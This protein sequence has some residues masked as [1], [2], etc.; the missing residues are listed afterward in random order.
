MSVCKSATEIAMEQRIDW[1][2]VRVLALLEAKRQVKRRLQSE[3]MVKVPL[4]S[5]STISRLAEDHLR[6]HPDLYKQ[7]MQSDLA[8]QN[9]TN[10]IKP[11]KP[12]NQPLLMCKSQVQK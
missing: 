10:S 11:Q 2:A 1:Q 6:T 4:L 7:A 12:G 5:A 3:G 8:L 9:S